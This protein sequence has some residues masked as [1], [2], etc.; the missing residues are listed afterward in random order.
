MNLHTEIGLSEGADTGQTTAACFFFLP[1]TQPMTPIPTAI[2]AK[3][4]DSGAVGMVG[5]NANLIREI[6][7]PLTHC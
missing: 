1:A 4:P 3:V 5:D 7:Q 2:N 6:F